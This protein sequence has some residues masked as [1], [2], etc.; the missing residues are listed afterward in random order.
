MEERLK[1]LSLLLLPLPL[2][3]TFEHAAVSQLLPYLGLD[4]RDTA[5]GGSQRRKRG[6]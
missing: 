4:L 6:L 5:E 3:R 2:D 1:A